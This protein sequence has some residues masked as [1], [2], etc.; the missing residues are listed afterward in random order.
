[1]ETT[2]RINEIIKKIYPK[3]FQPI[4]K[5]K[6]LLIKLKN[7]RLAIIAVLCF[8]FIA[9]GVH[10]GFYNKLIA[11]YTDAVTA[12][13][14]VRAYL[15]KRG[16]IVINLTKMVVD[17]AEHERM[18]YKYTADIRKEIIPQTEMILNTA[19]GIDM[20]NINDKEFS[21]FENLLSRFMAWSENYPDLKLNENFQDFMKEIVAVETDIADARVAYN[22]KVNAYTTFRSKFPNNIFA[23]VFR[24]KSI[25]F[26]QGSAEFQKF[27]EVKY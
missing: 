26:Y 9:V 3:D 22:G 23:V 25:E 1:M 7:N 5:K 16:N 2:N 20:V 8:L 15:Q 17:Y 18:M 10:V 27:Q 24:F 13:A 4:K 6:N 11:L 14:Q 21:K 19:K 12:K